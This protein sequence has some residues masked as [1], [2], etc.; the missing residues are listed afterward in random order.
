MNM[1]SRAFFLIVAGSAMLVIA[2]RARAGEFAPPLQTT[3]SSEAIAA[4]VGN[5]PRAATQAIDRAVSK[6]EEAALQLDFASNDQELNLLYSAH[7]L[8]ATAIDKL[9]CVQRERVAALEADIDHV[10]LRDNALFGPD[11]SPLGDRFGPPAPNRAQ[12]V[13]LVKEGQGLA[14]N[15]PG[16]FRLRSWD[17][18][19]ATGQ[20]PGIERGSSSMTPFGGP[21]D[22]VGSRLSDPIAAQSL[23]DPHS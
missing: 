18:P 9:C 19:I 22:K 16:E 21:G 6:L 5:P 23:S 13:R 4:N 8:L 3:P 10:I 2:S 12:L 7:D 1:G 17:T 15:M 20:A 11:A 14:R